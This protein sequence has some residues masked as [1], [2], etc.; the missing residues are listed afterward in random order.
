MM[1]TSSK[2][3]SHI[4]DNFITASHTTTMISC[5][6]CAKNLNSVKGYNVHITNNKIYMLNPLTDNPLNVYPSDKSPQNSYANKS[7]DSILEQC[8]TYVNQY[9]IEWNPEI[10]Y[11]IKEE[12]LGSTCSGTRETDDNDN[13][14]G[15]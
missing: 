2:K 5:R 14:I 3:N 8:I 6:I 7:S 13:T 10:C 12:K 15:F 4:F 1:T 9:N 11:E